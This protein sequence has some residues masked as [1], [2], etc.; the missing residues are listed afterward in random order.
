MFHFADRFALY[1]KITIKKIRGQCGSQWVQQPW[2]R[3]GGFPKEGLKLRQGL[4]GGGKT[5]RGSLG[6]HW[7][8]A[9]LVLHS[10]SSESVLCQLASGANMDVKIKVSRTKERKW[11]LLKGLAEVV[12]TS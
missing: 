2:K 9:G 10:L 12:H 11:G 4:T 7:G 6:L 8:V 3:P 1:K 5:S